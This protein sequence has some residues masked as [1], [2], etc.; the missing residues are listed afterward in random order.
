[1]CLPK[2]LP[3]SVLVQ[4]RVFYARLRACRILFAHRYHII[5]DSQPHLYLRHQVPEW[6]PDGD[7]VPPA[8]HGG[9]HTDFMSPGQCFG[10]SLYKKH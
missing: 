8:G 10:V 9:S 6:L 1:M 5:T 4:T 7:V 3:E 2:R